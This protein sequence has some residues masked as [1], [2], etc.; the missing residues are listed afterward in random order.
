MH[1]S[2]SHQANGNRARF[3]ARGDGSGKLRY[4]L[5]NALQGS[6]AIS[7]LSG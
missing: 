3:N 2:K 5:K 7:A 6:R 4:D 1:L